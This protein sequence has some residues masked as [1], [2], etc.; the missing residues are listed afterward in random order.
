[1]HPAALQWQLSSVLNASASHTE[2][3]HRTIVV[4]IAWEGYALLFL[5]ATRTV[6]ELQESTNRVAGRTAKNL[7]QHRFE[8]C[9]DSV[10]AKLAG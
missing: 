1:V 6:R 2:E 4:G 7:M 9:W 8:S 10:V 5:A 3:A